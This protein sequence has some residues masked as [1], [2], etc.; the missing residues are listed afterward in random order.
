MTVPAHV[1]LMRRAALAPPFKSKQ[2]FGF[3]GYSLPLVHPMRVHIRRGSRV[4][5]NVFIGIVS[6]LTNTS[7]RLGLGSDIIQLKQ[8]L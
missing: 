4:N 8:V 1:A 7:L 3:Y 5:T 6:Y 2:S